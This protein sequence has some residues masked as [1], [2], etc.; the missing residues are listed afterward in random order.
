MP[1]KICRGF[2]AV[3]RALK[4]LF[5]RKLWSVTLVLIVMWVSACI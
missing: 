2:T 5:S 4:Q 3:W 1:A